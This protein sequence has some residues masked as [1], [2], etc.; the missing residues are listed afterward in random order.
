MIHL[1]G[2]EVRFGDF[3]AL[4]DI[5]IHVKEGELVPSCCG[6]LMEILD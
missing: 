5:N 3:T 2:I 4:K 1:N 6:R